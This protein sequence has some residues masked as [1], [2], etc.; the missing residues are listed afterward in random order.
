VRPCPRRGNQI[1]QT[2]HGGSLRSSA[3]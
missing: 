3:I 2:Q 1:R